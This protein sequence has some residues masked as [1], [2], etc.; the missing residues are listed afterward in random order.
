MSV[1]EYKI[2]KKFILV[3]I[4]ILAILAVEFLV[5]YIMGKNAQV[6]SIKLRNM[7]GQTIKS[8]IIRHDN[9]NRIV[10]NIKKGKSKI[11]RFYS[12]KKNSYTIKAVFED[13]EALFSASRIVQPG[14]FLF[15]TVTDTAFIFKEK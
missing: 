9:G 14:F 13:D 11:V 10:N 4:L 6:V 2:M 7:S 5:G 8:A 15:E 1:M 3:G 12:N